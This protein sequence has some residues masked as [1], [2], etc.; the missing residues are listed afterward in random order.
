MSVPLLRFS[1]PVHL[2]RIILE[3]GLRELPSGKTF[4]KQRRVLITGVKQEQVR[5]WMESSGTGWVDVKFGGAE[6]GKKLIV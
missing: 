3:C 5:V 6:R 2:R 4:Y 1:D